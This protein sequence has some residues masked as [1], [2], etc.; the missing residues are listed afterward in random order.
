MPTWGKTSEQFFMRQISILKDAKFLKVIIITGYTDQNKWNHIPIISLQKHSNGQRIWHYLK[1]KIKSE[2]YK[3]LLIDKIKR[4]LKHYQID[5]LL[6]QY[7][8][9]AVAIK[10]A[11]ESIK[12]RIFVHVHGFDTQEQSCPAGH[13]DEF[14]NLSSQLT[15]ICNSK[16]T[17]NRLTKWGVSQD[18]LVIKYMGVDIPEITPNTNSQFTILSLGRLVDCK[19]PDRTIQAFELARDKGLNAQLIIAGDGPLKV[20]CE[21]LRVRSKWKDAI[22]L[23]GE[24]TW[25]QGKQLY[26]RADMF[27]QHAMVGELTGRIEAFGVSIIEAMAYALP[28]S[29][30]KIGGIAESVIENETGLFFEPEDIEQQANTFIQLANNQ[31]LRI[32]LGNNA[33]Q[34]VKDH[35]SLDIEAKNLLD[36]LKSEK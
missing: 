33:R 1:R 13:K 25:E 22:Q 30:S 12:Y 8:T 29:T 26:K 16:E 18:N 14:L 23:T 24:V 20:T 5:T 34:R 27:T 15:T 4:A 3:Y 35:F 7:G 31:E 17:Y 19:S 36:I 10:E 32:K 28:V 2:P 6:I 11:L 21:L 9:T